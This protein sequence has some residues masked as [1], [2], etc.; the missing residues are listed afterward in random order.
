M[1][2]APARRRQEVLKLRFRCAAYYPAVTD[3]QLA[4]EPR[5]RQRFYSQRHRGGGFLWTRPVVI[6]PTD[7]TWKITATLRGL[8]T[9]L[10]PTKTQSVD[11]PLPGQRHADR[12]ACRP[13][14]GR[15]GFDVDTFR[16]VLGRKDTLGGTRGY[17]SVRS[18][19]LPTDLARGRRRDRGGPSLSAT[20]H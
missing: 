10:R 18:T 4:T 1:R 9:T 11:S 17:V 6:N 12:H 15:R 13:P 2:P 8:W 3:F 16:A 14:A 7:L 19:H 5:R 20:L